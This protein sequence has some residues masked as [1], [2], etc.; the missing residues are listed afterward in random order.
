MR[1]WEIRLVTGVIPK[2]TPRELPVHELTFGLNGKRRLKPE[3]IAKR[4]G[5]SASE[6]SKLRSSIWNKLLDTMGAKLS[7][8]MCGN[9]Q[10][11]R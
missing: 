7:K 8:R 10:G 1:K 4:L 3:G 6:V 11:T 9:C 2:L 5:M